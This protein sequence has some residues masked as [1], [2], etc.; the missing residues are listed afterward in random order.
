M[1]ALSHFLLLLAAAS[2]TFCCRPSQTN[3]RTSIN[4]ALLQLS[5]AV[6]ATFTHLLLRN[7]PDNSLNLSIIKILLLITVSHLTS[8]TEYIRKDYDS[9]QIHDYQYLKVFQCKV[10]KPSR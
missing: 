4:E 8:Y 9:W 3:F 5:N 6:H 10:R 7:T 1:Q 2:I